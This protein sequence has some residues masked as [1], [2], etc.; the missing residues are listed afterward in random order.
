MSSRE[1]SVGASSAANIRFSASVSPR[2]SRDRRRRGGASLARGGGGERAHPNA[3]LAGGIE[4]SRPDSVAVTPDT[5]KRL[6]E[7][8]LSRRLVSPDAVRAGERE[9]ERRVRAGRAR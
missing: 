2:G 6:F 4:A 9:R 3:P 7:L 1:S 5:E 8:A